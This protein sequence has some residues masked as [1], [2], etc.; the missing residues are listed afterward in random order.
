M[1]RILLSLI[2]TALVLSAATAYAQCSCQ[3][4]VSS[5]AIQP[6][7]MDDTAVSAAGDCPTCCPRCRTKHLGRDCCPATAWH[8]QYYGYYHGSC[9]KPL[10]LVVPP[11]ARYQTNWAWGVGGTQVTPI[12][13]QFQRG[14]PGDVIGSPGGF[15]PTPRWPSNTNQFGVYYIRGPW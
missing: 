8:G 6:V 2:M 13:A 1:T 15:Y 4:D 10:A 14:Y 7:P 11:T 12:H 3:S 9:G 5:A